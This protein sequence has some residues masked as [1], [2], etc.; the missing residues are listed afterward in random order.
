MK[1]AFLLSTRQDL[2]DAARSALLAG[3]HSASANGDTVQFRDPRGRLFTMFDGPDPELDW[4]VR[5]GPYILAGGAVL[6]DMASVAIC[7]IECRWEDLFASV[8]SE[9]AD[10]LLAPSWVLDSNGVLWPASDV[11]P[12]R[13]TL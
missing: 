5:E 12:S 9:I 4:E 2:F 3:P 10:A 8:V 7:I 1:S 6:P 13:I 11:D